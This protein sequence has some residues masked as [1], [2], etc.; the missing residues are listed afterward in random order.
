[1]NDEMLI[2]ALEKEFPGY[3]FQI[4]EMKKVNKTPYKA[5]LVNEK[6]DNLACAFNLDSMPEGLSFDE[7]VEGIAKNIHFAMKNRPDIN[8]KVDD[9]NEFR[10][11]L[12]KHIKIELYPIKDEKEYEG[13]FWEKLTDD[14][15]IVFKYNLGSGEALI[16]KSLFPDMTLDD[17]K[18]I[19]YEHAPKNFPAEI[20]TLIKKMMQLSQEM[21]I[22][23]EQL[24]QD[25][26]VLVTGDDGLLGA[27]AILYPDV[28]E[29]LYKY[30]DDE[31]YILPSSK[32]EVL[33]LGCKEDIDW[34]RNTVAEINK[35]EVSEDDFLSNTIL[36]YDRNLGKIVEA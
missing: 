25:E 15:A 34:I 27:G 24:E 5:L 22:P 26:T 17:I 21:N 1:M 31:Y 9:I 14:I 10:D 7:M 29:R 32:H 12:E 36:K 18:M 30:F 33:C 28:Q 16:S 11:E 20:C 8:L 3:E 23:I 35:T 13:Y 19:A 6:G 2:N 4:K